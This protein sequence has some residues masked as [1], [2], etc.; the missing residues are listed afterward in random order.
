MSHQS[1]ITHLSY[2]KTGDMARRHLDGAVEFLGRRDHQVKIRGFRV[3]LNEIESRLKE[4]TT[5]KHTASVLEEPL[6]KSGDM[7]GIVRCSRCLLSAN[8]PGIV[9]DSEGVCSVCREYDGYEHQVRNYFKTLPELEQLLEKAKGPG[10]R[11]DCL[12]LY[13]GGKDSTYVLYRLIDMGLKVLTYTFDNGYISQSAFENIERTTAALKVDHIIGK[14]R[15]MN[16]VLVESLETNH[17]VCHGCWNA[18]N[19]HGTK[20]AEE[21]GIDLVISGLSRGQ[22]FEMRLHGL[23]QAGIFDEKEIREKLLLFRK[24]FHSNENKFS[25]LLD[26]QIAEEAVE[27]IQF[28]DYFRYDATRV[29]EIKKYLMGKGWEQPRDTGFCSSNCRINDIGIYMYIKERGVHFY[30]APLSWDVRLGQITRQAG[31]DEIDFQPEPR[32]VDNV[33]R[34]IGY[35]NTAV[36][37][38]VKVLARTGK[39]GDKYLCGYIVSDS[40]ISARELRRHLAGKLPDYMIPTHF[41]QVEKIPL[42]IGGKVDD[43]ALASLETHGRRLSSD[44]P[45]VPPG[46]ENAILAANLFK[47]LLNLDQVGIDDNFFEIGATSYEIIQV[48]RQLSKA[49]GREIPVVKLFEYP[50]IASF[51]EYLNGEGISAREIQ[52]EVK[53]DETMEKGKSRYEQRRKMRKI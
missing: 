34:E 19:A 37:K 14:D 30:E 22:I 21:K 35:Y 10:S 46:D 32:E 11:Y 12:L 49:F 24:G 1:Y 45:Y 26:L 23:F 48:N 43:K 27:R 36:I 28:V 20:L 33:L 47:E 2:Y 8:H 3:E 41:F 16:R 44:A 13:S 9:F 39:N 40:E 51:L 15:H 6:V 38:D 29:E 50:T 31:I 53:R 17:T 4:F 5:K 25:R 42:T 52:A 18:L 7:Q